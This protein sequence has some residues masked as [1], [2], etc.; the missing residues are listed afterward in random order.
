M[1]PHPLL[2]S[3]TSFRI[4]ALELMHSVGG[5]LGPMYD[6]LTAAPTATKSRKER[7]LSLLLRRSSEPL[8]SSCYPLKELPVIHKSTADSWSDQILSEVPLSTAWQPH[9]PSHCMSFNAVWENCF[10]CLP[11]NLHTLAVLQK[12]TALEPGM[13]SKGKH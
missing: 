12:V 1:D 3:R 9:P 6:T 4:A 10:Q 2:S 8:V 13:A 5:T 7:K 11:F